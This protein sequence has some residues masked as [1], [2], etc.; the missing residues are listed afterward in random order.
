MGN[1][2]HWQ[3]IKQLILPDSKDNTDVE[4]IRQT[5]TLKQIHILI[6][7]KSN[8]YVKFKNKIKLKKNIF[9]VTPSDQFPT[10]D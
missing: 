1:N 6:F 3:E 10:R 9:K 8:S 2:I 5:G 7:G 4:T